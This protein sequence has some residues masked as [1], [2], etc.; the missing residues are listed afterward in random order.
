MIARILALACWLAVAVVHAQPARTALVLSPQQ[1]DALSTEISARL[2]GEL[3]AEGFTV[4]RRTSTLPPQL[5]VESA[6]ED[7]SAVLLIASSP[8]AIWLSDRLAGHTSMARLQVEQETLTPSQLTVRAVELLRAR[9]SERVVSADVWEIVP[10]REV[11]EVPTPEAPDPITFALGV[12]GAWLRGLGSTWLPVAH[13]AIDVPLTPRFALELSL[14]GGA[15]STQVR[16]GREEGS[17][18]VG[19]AFGAVVAALKLRSQPELSLRVGA[20]A[21]GLQVDGRATPPFEARD[22]LNLSP[23]VSAGCGVRSP[24]WWHLALAASA[25]VLVLTRP[26]VVMVARQ[27]VAHLGTASALLRAELVAIF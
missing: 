18:I 4:T 5:A 1:G 11:I 22:S 9:L 8:L 27:E 13:V 24:V 21:H 17:A 3:A 14:S 12:G 16:A 20:G 6:Q 15:F 10:P 23:F 19:Q 7:A 2:S 25:D 26:S